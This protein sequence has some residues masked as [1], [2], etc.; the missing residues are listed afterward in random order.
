[1]SWFETFKQFKPFKTLGNVWNDLN[2]LN[3]W[4]GPRIKPG[5]DNQPKN[6]V[7]GQKESLRSLL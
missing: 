5:L 3:D 4:N 2:Y 1:M 6:R 7:E